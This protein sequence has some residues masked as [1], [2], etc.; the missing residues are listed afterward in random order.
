M[1]AFVSPL[2]PLG[3]IPAAGHS[4]MSL[5]SCRLDSRE[6]I[7]MPHYNYRQVVVNGRIQ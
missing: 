5:V 6:D 1:C 7:C 3:L 4:K 2:F